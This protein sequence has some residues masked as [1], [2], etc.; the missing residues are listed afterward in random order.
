MNDVERYR[1]FFLLECQPILNFPVPPLWLI[2]AKIWCCFSDLCPSDSKFLSLSVKSI[3]TMLITPLPKPSQFSAVIIY[4]NICSCSI[5]GYLQIQ[6]N[7][8]FFWNLWLRI[9][10]NDGR[11][12][13]S[14]Y[15]HTIQPKVWVE[16]SNIIYRKIEKTNQTKWVQKGLCFFP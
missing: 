11:V 15:F 12:W 14:H 3:Q 8:S 7:F 10:W 9:T 6:Q 1:I 5:K 16:P 4:F 2:A 13:F